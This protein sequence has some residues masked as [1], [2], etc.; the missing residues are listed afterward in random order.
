MNSWHVTDGY[1]FIGKIFFN[2]ENT[3]RKRAKSLCKSTDDGADKCRKCGIRC[4]FPPKTNKMKKLFFSLRF[5]NFFSLA[6]LTI[7]ILIKKRKGDEESW[8][9]KKE[10][11]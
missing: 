7:I 6:Y 5:L 2:K 4:I 3:K 1:L 8:K 9:R 10:F 11:H